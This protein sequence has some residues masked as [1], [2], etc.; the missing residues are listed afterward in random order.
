[1]AVKAN[2]KNEH[3]ALRLAWTLITPLDI[4]WSVKPSC[5]SALIPSLKFLSEIHA[6]L[7]FF[8][9]NDPINILSNKKFVC[10]FALF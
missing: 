5:N 1:L 6:G 4:F 8:D 3:V 10:F 7:K 2:K 9:L